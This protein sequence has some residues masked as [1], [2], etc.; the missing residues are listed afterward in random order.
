MDHEAVTRLLARNNNPRRVPRWEPK[1][2]NA[3]APIASPSKT[4]CA[5]CTDKPMVIVETTS[6]QR[7]AHAPRRIMVAAAKDF[8]SVVAATTK[9]ITAMPW[10]G[11][12]KKR[13]R[14]QRNTH[15][16]YKE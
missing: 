4:W 12:C 9:T 11:I 8:R 1:Q 15:S 13:T 3:G 5:N 10:H 2:K 14:Y 6:N 16:A 7:H